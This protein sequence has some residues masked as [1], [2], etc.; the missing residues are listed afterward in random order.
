MVSVL[1]FLFDLRMNLT[2][3]EL[4]EKIEAELLG[5]SR[6]VQKQVNTVAAVTSAGENDVTFVKVPERYGVT[7]G[8]SKVKKTG[9]LANTKA[10]GIILP[11]ALEGLQKPQL[12]VKNVE[13]ALI[14][15]LEIFAPRLKPAETGIHPTASVAKNV[16]IAENASIGPYVVVEDGAQI[17]E[18]TIIG[19]GCCIGQNTKI[20]PETRL[21]CNVVVYH[22]CRIGRNV[23]I[24]ANTTI[25]STGFGYSSIKGKNVLIPHN[26]SVIIEDFVEIG[27]NCCIDRAKFGNTLIGAGTKIDNLVQ[28][29]HNV[30]IGKACLIAALVGIAGSSKLGD[31][32][33]MGGQA[34]L[35]DNIEVGSEAM[36]GGHTP[37]FQNVPP[38]QRVFGIPPLE[39][40]ES[41]R[42]MGLMKRLPQ[43]AEQIKQLNK[44]IEK[45]EA[46][47]NYKK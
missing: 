19:T 10:A 27:A 47:K 40:K 3:Q 34:G 36:I 23:I 41:L 28:I 7:T 17:A 15:A 45:I 20:G 1:L 11:R 44:R 39:I 9:I 2:I 33:V 12:I 43:L 32:V 8:T 14:Q 5:N 24:Q 22:N 31:G 21:D 25:G 6:Q 42:I 13:H 37:I 4:A 16:K 29:A 30:Q 26:G 38:K 35:A 46:A 18:N